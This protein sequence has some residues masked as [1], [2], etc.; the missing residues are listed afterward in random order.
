MDLTLK[1]SE[2]EYSQQRENSM[3]KIEEL[4]FAGRE[5]RRKGKEFLN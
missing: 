1:L 2:L 5:G 3:R 4:I